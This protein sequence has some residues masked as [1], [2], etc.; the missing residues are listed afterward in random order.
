MVILLILLIIGTDLFKFKEKNPG[1]TGNN[2][3]KNVE[4]IV[5][6]K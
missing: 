6:L 5:P 2:G 4:I 3:S 1:E